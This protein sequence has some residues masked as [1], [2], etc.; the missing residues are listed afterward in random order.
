[1]LQALESGVP[2]GAVNT[3]GVDPRPYV[4]NPNDAYLTP[5][6]STATT[7]FFGPRDE[8]HTEGQIRTDFA[9]NYVHADSRSRADA[10]VRASCRC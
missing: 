6:S 4:T 3:N 2:Y 7:Y 8:F 9:A 1:M 5:P 10:A